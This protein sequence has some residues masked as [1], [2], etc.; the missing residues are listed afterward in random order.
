MR[1]TQVQTCSAPDLTRDFAFR[2][3]NWTSRLRKKGE[4]ARRKGVPTVFR[5]LSVS[6][7]VSSLIKSG[8]RS[9]S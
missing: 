1:K 6:R 2:S 7:A 4:F 5:S 3:R 8:D 9:K